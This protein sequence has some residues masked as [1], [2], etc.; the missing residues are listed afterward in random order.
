[1]LAQAVDRR[2]KNARRS[3]VPAQN[4]TKRL[5][6]N[7]DQYSTIAE[8]H[9]F[10][11]L[12]LAETTDFK[13]EENWIAQR[14]RLNKTK[15]NS[16]L[17]RLLRLGLLE[18]HSNGELVP[19]GLSYATPDEVR[20][21]SVRRAHF[22]NLELA[23][24]SLERDDISVRDFGAMTM[25]IDPDLLP[26]AKRRIREFRQELSQFLESGQKQSV[27]KIC[28]QLFPL[29]ETNKETQEP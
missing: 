7:H 1:M 11:I 12:S 6:L 15:V 13:S 25:A 3:S 9:H 17:N 29:T 20:D 18:K 22:Q 24:N 10:A 26:E 5:Q 21:M 16:A 14:L 27:Y 2:F 19:T 28:M 8:W 4:L 23:R